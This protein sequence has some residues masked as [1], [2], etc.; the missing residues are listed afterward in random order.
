MRTFDF[1]FLMH[2][3]FNWLCNYLLNQMFNSIFDVHSLLI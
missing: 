3:T 2:K 1:E